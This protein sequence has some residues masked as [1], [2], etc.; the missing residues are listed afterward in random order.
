VV[1]L[2]TPLSGGLRKLATLLEELIERHALFS[3]P[4]DEMTER[5]DALYQ[6][7]YSFEVLDGPIRR[8]ASIFSWLALILR[9]ETMKPRSLPFGTL[10]T[11]FWWRDI[12]KSITKFKEL[13]H[14]DIKDGC[15][16]Q[17]WL[18]RWDGRTSSETY[19]ELFSF[20]INKNISV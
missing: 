4:G 14:G 20:I 11:H 16:T 18:N 6:A 17:L 10:N 2:G 8:M 13:S 19:L 5:G 9:S 7:L 3:E 1:R 15:T 12:L